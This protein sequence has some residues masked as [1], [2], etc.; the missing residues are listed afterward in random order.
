M[1]TLLDEPLASLIEA[2]PD[3]AVSPEAGALV[4][5]MA[6]LAFSV[7]TASGQPDVLRTLAA[8]TPTALLSAFAE[9]VAAYSP[10]NPGARL[11]LRGRLALAEALE[12]TGGLWRADE[13]QAALGVG[14]A[15]LQSWRDGRKVLALPLPGGSFGYP[16]AQFAPPASD[17]ARPRPQPGLAAVLA[18]AGDAL[19]SQELFLLLATSQPA[20]AGQTGF[21]AL[22]A[23][24][25]SEVAAL[26]AHLTTPA[27]AGAP[28]AAA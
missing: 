27:D 28:P 7:A 21:E 24:G 19:T 17:L 5:R 12:R 10:A 16:V 23:G 3:A 6:S 20:L 25:G 18:A 14:R 4:A 26:V 2:H 15:T 8:G 11:A 13:A 22:A 1:T 9:L